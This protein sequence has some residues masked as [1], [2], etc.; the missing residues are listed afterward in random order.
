MSAESEMK[1]SFLVTYYNQEK[2]VKQSLESILAIEKPDEWE[3]LIGDDASTDGTCQEVQKY[4]EQDSKHIKL[5]RRTDE[6]K[7]GLTKLH[8]GPMNRLSLLEKASGDYFVTLDG[9]D[10]YSDKAFVREAIAIMEEN[11]N[12]SVV[13]FGNRTISHGIV[14]GEFL[15]PKEG[16]ITGEEYLSKKWHIHA[17]AC[18]YRNAFDENKIDFLKQL[19]LFDDHSIPITNLEY[20]DIYF[21][22]RVIYNYRYLENSVYYPESF[23]VK[24][25]YIATWISPVLLA[26][27]ERLKTVTKISYYDSVIIMYIYRKEIKN[28]PREKYREIKKMLEAYCPSEIYD[29]FCYD[30]LNLK[31]FWCLR[32]KIINGHRRDV[33]DKYC[34]RVKENL[35]SRFSKKINKLPYIRGLVMENEML[36]AQLKEMSGEDQ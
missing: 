35:K 30:S 20:G 6:D 4:V 12:I 5:F 15:L 10:W 9:D 23:I 33:F 26:V 7:K 11:P 25:C 17:G 1:I 3:I 24:Y 13:M 16:Y 14:T 22:P 32:N 19:H 36:K 18:V 27:P 34:A 8:M 31:E 2:Y 21:V 28:I 29:L